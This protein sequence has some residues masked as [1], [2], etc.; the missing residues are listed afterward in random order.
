MHAKNTDDGWMDLHG[1][2][3]TGIADVADPDLLN[4]RNADEADLM[5]LRG[6]TRTGITDVADA[7][8]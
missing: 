2:T 8:L 6:Y 3:R 5:D 7:D 4:I 1:Y